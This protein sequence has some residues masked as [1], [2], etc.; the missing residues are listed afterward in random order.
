MSINNQIDISN[1][2]ISM[3]NGYVTRKGEKVRVLC[4]DNY[5]NPEFPV[6][7]IVGDGDIGSFTKNGLYIDTCSPCDSD[8]IDIETYKNSQLKQGDIIVVGVFK[9]TLNHMRVF[10]HFDEYGCCCYCFDSGMQSGDVIG[11][12]HYRK[13]TEEEIARAFLAFHSAPKVV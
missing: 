12:D 6:V 11:W 3:N 1:Q 7:A 10:S 2:I 13:A 9:D 4:T 8:L 5:T